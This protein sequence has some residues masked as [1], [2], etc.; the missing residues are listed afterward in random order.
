MKARPISLLLIAAFTAGASAQ[1][2]TSPI[3]PA[4]AGAVGISD[5]RMLL[6]DDL[7]FQ[8]FDFES[9]ENFCM[10]LGYEHQIDGQL[11][12]VSTGHGLCN[13]AGRN[14]LIVMMRLVDDERILSFGLHD[15]D[16]GMG[17][18]MALANL[19]IGSVSGWATREVV[20]TIRAD[21]EAALF[22]WRYG[23]NP[24]RPGPYHDVRIMVRLGE[25]ERPLIG[26]F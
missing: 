13:V 7:Q 1:P 2:P 16:T 26:N 3:V 23:L 20:Q 4:N 6:G 11:S 10:H 15:R 12:S 14:R 18:T 19:P 9:K 8:M 17:T 22:V 21:Q 25:N 5:L 24:P